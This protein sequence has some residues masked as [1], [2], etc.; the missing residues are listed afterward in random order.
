MTNPPD[1]SARRLRIKQSV[2]HQHLSAVERDL[3]D[4]VN[5]QIGPNFQAKIVLR[6]SA[7]R[8]EVAKRKKNDQFSVPGTSKTVDPEAGKHLREKVLVVSQV[9]TNGA[10]VRETHFKLETASVMGPDLRSGNLYAQ[11]DM[12]AVQN[13]IMTPTMVLNDTSR[14]RLPVIAD[15]HSALTGDQFLSSADVA[16]RTIVGSI[17]HQSNSTMHDRFSEL[18][19]H[20]PTVAPDYRG[21]TQLSGPHLDPNQSKM[22]AGLTAYVSVERGPGMQQSVFD[23]LTSS[24]NLA[25]S[26]YQEGASASTHAGFQAKERRH[27]PNKNTVL[28]IHSAASMQGGLR[29]SVGISKDSEGNPTTLTSMKENTEESAGKSKTERKKSAEKQL[30][31]REAVSQRQGIIP[32]NVNPLVSAQYREKTGAVPAEGFLGVL[33]FGSKVM[34]PGGVDEKGNPL[35]EYAAQM[36]A[37]GSGGMVGSFDAYRMRGESAF[38]D[39]I[40]LMPRSANIRD[41]RIVAGRGAFIPASGGVIATWGQSAITGE[42]IETRMPNMGNRGGVRV[43]NHIL[44][45]G[46]DE[47]SARHI[48]DLIQSPDVTLSYIHGLI[49]D[50]DSTKKG[51]AKFKERIELEQKAIKNLNSTLKSSVEKE[52]AAIDRTSMSPEDIA[53]LEKDKQEDIR[54]SVIKYDRKAVGGKRE[55]TALISSTSYIQ[56]PDSMKGGGFKAMLGHVETD[57]RSQEIIKSVLNGRASHEIS[58]QEINEV[59]LPKFVSEFGLKKGRNQQIS[60]V[61]LQTLVGNSVKNV[62]FGKGW[63]KLQQDKDIEEISQR[64]ISDA[65]KSRLIKQIK[66]GKR[67]PLTPVLVMTHDEIK[68]TKDLHLRTI[69]TYLQQSAPDSPIGSGTAPDSAVTRH[70]KSMGE[71]IRSEYGT[72]GSSTSGMDQEREIEENIR[73]LGTTEKEASESYERRNKAFSSIVTNAMEYGGRPWI[74]TSF[75]HVN[76]EPMGTTNMVNAPFARAITKVSPELRDYLRKNNT[77]SKKISQMLAPESWSEDEAVDITAE[78][79]RTLIPNERAADEHERFEAVKRIYDN[80][81]K[82]RKSTKNAAMRLTI[83]TDEKGN[84]KQIVL[85]SP[86][87][88][89]SLERSDPGTTLTRLVEKVQNKGASTA[90][91]EQLEVIHRKAVQQYAQSDAGQKRMQNFSGEGVNAM[92]LRYVSSPDASPG[93]VLVGNQDI[94]SVAS[95]FGISSKQMIRAMRSGQKF[96]VYV[97]RYPQSEGSGAWYEME[98]RKKYKGAIAVP[99]EANSQFAGDDDGDLANFMAGFRPVTY[100]KNGKMSTEFVPLPGVEQAVIDQGSAKVTALNR[101]ASFYGFKELKSRIQEARGQVEK[102][103]TDQLEHTQEFQD[104][105]TSTYGKIDA[106]KDPEM[107]KRAFETERDRRTIDAMVS[108]FNFV[109][110]TTNRGYHVKKLNLE[111]A[112]K[113]QNT[114]LDAETKMVPVRA[115]ETKGDRASIISN[116]LGQYAVESAP[117]VIAHQSAGEGAAKRDMGIYTIVKNLQYTAETPEHLKAIEKASFDIYGENPIEGLGR[118]IRPHQNPYASASSQALSDLDWIY[119]RALD[120][121]PKH[122]ETKTL[123]KSFF[124][125]DINTSEDLFKRKEMTENMLASFLLAEEV[126]PI[127]IGATFARRGNADQIKFITESA[128]SIKDEI[129]KKRKESGREVTL[130]DLRQIQ[131]FNSIIDGHGFDTTAYAEDANSAV[132][133]TITHQSYINTIARINN[134]KYDDATVDQKEKINDALK[135]YLGKIV[136]NPGT[137][138]KDW[139]TVASMS[140]EKDPTGFWSQAVDQ[141]GGMEHLTNMDPV[142]IADMFGIKLEIPETPGEKDRQMGKRMI[143]LNSFASNPV[144]AFAKLTGFGTDMIHPDIAVDDETQ[145]KYRQAMGNARSINSS[146]KIE[147]GKPRGFNARAS[148]IQSIVSFPDNEKDPRR[149]AYQFADVGS[150]IYKS[151]AVFEIMNQM[152]VDLL[153]GNRTNTAMFRDESLPHGF[154]N[155]SLGKNEYTIFQQTNQQMRGGNKFEENL[156]RQLIDAM[157]NAAEESLK[158]GSTRTK[159][160]QGFL[161]MSGISLSALDE[162]SGMFFSGTPDFFRM[163]GEK[164]KGEDGWQL[165]LQVYDAKSTSVGKALR[166]LGFSIEDIEDV[167]RDKL[168]DVGLSDDFGVY[169]GQISSYVYLAQKMA[170][171]MRNDAAK[172]AGRALE[173]KKKPSSSDPFSDM[174]D[175]AEEE[176]S[177]VE[178][179]GSFKDLDIEGVNV[180]SKYAQHINR[181][182]EML[183]EQKVRMFNGEGNEMTHREIAIGMAE[184]MAAGRIEEGGVI[185]GNTDKSGKRLFTDSKVLGKI[186]SSGLTIKTLLQNNLILS[187]RKLPA[188]GPQS[189]EGMLRAFPRKAKQIAASDAGLRA[190]GFMYHA[191]GLAMMNKNELLGRNRETGQIDEN[192]TYADLSPLFGVLRENLSADPV[193]IR[194]GFSASGNPFGDD[195]PATPSGYRRSWT[196]E[197]EEAD[198]TASVL[199]TMMQHSQLSAQQISS[200]EYIL[201]GFARKADKT[202]SIS[203][204]KDGNAIVGR[205][206]KPVAGKFN[207]LLGDKANELREAVTYKNSAN[208]NVIA[209]DIA[210]REAVIGASAEYGNDGKTTSV[211]SS[212]Q[213]KYMLSGGVR[214]NRLSYIST[215]AR[216]VLNP[217]S[218]KEDAREILKERLAAQAESIQKLHK[219]AELFDAED[220]AKL[221]DMPHSVDDL[222]NAA[223]AELIHNRSTSF[224]QKLMD[225]Y[226][227][228]YEEIGESSIRFDNNSLVGYDPKTGQIG[229]RDEQIENK[230]TAFRL[231]SRMFSIG[232]MM[233]SAQMVMMR[234]GYAS[235]Q[236]MDKEGK[237]LKRVFNQKTN[238]ELDDILNP[239]GESKRNKTKA[240]RAS[241]ARSE[242]IGKKLASLAKSFTKRSKHVYTSKDFAQMPKGGAG[243]NDTN[244]WFQTPVTNQYEGVGAFPAQSDHRSWFVSHHL[245]P[246]HAIAKGLMEMGIRSNQWKKENVDEEILMGMLMTHDLMKAKTT[247]GDLRKKDK[248]AAAGRKYDPEED[249]TPAFDMLLKM[250]M[251]KEK[252]EK[253]KQYLSDMDAVKDPK[254]WEKDQKDQDGNPISIEDKI[255]SLSPEV[256]IASTADAISHRTKGRHGFLNIFSR[257][258]NKAKDKPSTL[259]K[260]AESN[261][262]KSS[263]DSRKILMDIGDVKRSEV[264]SDAREAYD[265]IT[266]E[267]YVSGFAS[268]IAQGL[269]DKFG[270][271]QTKSIFDK[272][273]NAFGDK[274]KFSTID[275][276]TGEMKPFNRTGK[277]RGGRLRKGDIDIVGE[278]EK[279][280]VFSKENGEMIVEPGTKRNKKET[281][282]EFGQEIISPG[283][284]GELYVSPNSA[285]KRRD[286]ES[287]RSQ[288]RI[289]F[290]FGIAKHEGGPVEKETG[291]VVGENKSEL[292]APVFS[293][294]SDEF[295]EGSVRYAYHKELAKALFK[296]DE[297]RTTRGNIVGLGAG[298]SKPEKDLGIRAEYVSLH[299]SIFS[300]RI[301]SWSNWTED[302]DQKADKHLFFDEDEKPATDVL[303]VLKDYF[304]TD[305]PEMPEFHYS[306]EAGK[307][308]ALGFYAS[309][310]NKK[311]RIVLSKRLKGSF[312]VKGLF[313]GLH[314][315]GHFAHFSSLGFDHDHPEWGEDRNSIIKQEAFANKFAKHHGNK[316]IGDTPSLNIFNQRVLL[317][318]SLYEKYVDDYVLSGHDWSKVARANGGPVGKDQSYVAGEHETEEYARLVKEGYGLDEAGPNEGI[319]PIPLGGFRSISENLLGVEAEG[320]EVHTEGPAAG[321][322]KYAEWAAKTARR[323]HG[324]SLGVDVFDMVRS[325][326]GDILKYLPTMRMSDKSR[327]SYMQ[328]VAGEHSSFYR[329]P[330]PHW[331]KLFRAGKNTPK[332]DAEN[333]AGVVIA[334]ISA[335]NSVEHLALLS[336]EIGHYED[337]FAHGFAEGTTGK[338]SWKDPESYEKWMETEA[339]ASINAM[340]NLKQMLDPEK[341]RLASQTLLRNQVLYERTSDLQ[342][343]SM[344]G[345][346]FDDVKNTYVSYREKAKARRSSARAEGGPVESGSSY[347]AGEINTETYASRLKD[348]LKGFLV[349]QEGKKFWNINEGGVSPMDPYGKKFSEIPGIVSDSIREE[350][351]T[352]DPGYSRKLYLQSRGISQG[353]INSYEKRFAF[354][355][356]YIRNPFISLGRKLLAGFSIPFGALGSFGK[357]VKNFL[358]GIRFDKKEDG[359]RSLSFPKFEMD[360][361]SIP[362]WAKKDLS[363]FN[364]GGKFQF[365]K[366]DF[367][368]FF[369]N[370]FDKG[371]AFAGKLM[372]GDGSESPSRDDM[373]KYLKYREEAWQVTKSLDE[374]K[375]SMTPG[376]DELDD[377]DAASVDAE[378]STMAAVYLDKRYKDYRRAKT[379][380]EKLSV[381]Q[382]SFSAVQGSISAKSP[383]DIESYFRVRRHMQSGGMGGIVG[384]VI[385]GA[386]ETGEDIVDFAR[387]IPGAVSK[388][389]AFVGNAASRFA[390][391]AKEI[392]SGI[393][394]FASSQFGKVFN[395]VDA[396]VQTVKQKAGNVFGYAKDV[397]SAL[398]DGYSA[399]LGTGTKPSRGMDLFRNAFDGI[400]GFAER[401]RTGVNNLA[402]RTN[403]GMQRFFYGRTPEKGEV[404][405]YLNNVVEKGNAPYW[406][407]EKYVHEYISDRTGFVG[408]L[409]RTADGAANAITSIG[410][411]PFFNDVRGAISDVASDFRG[412]ASGAASKIND[413]ASEIWS[414]RKPTEKEFVEYAGRKRFGVND[415]DSYVQRYLQNRTGLSNVVNSVGS[416]AGRVALGAGMAAGAVIGGV[417]MGVGAGLGLVGSAIGAVAS[418]IFS[419]AG[420]FA[421]VVGENVQTAATD[422]SSSAKTLFSFA[423]SAL[424][425]RASAAKSFAKQTYQSSKEFAG[426]AYQWAKQSA[427]NVAKFG[428]AAGGFALEGVKAAGTLA[429]IPFLAAGALVAAPFVMA[430][431]AAYRGAQDALFGRKPSKESMDEYLK[432]KDAY[433]NLDKQGFLTSELKDAKNWHEGKRGIVSG[434]SGFAEKASQAVSAFSNR[435]SR[436]ASVFAGKAKGVF[437]NVYSAVSK[438]ASTIWKGEKPHMRSL[439]N[440]RGNPEY[441][442][443]EIKEGRGTADMAYASRYAR[444]RTGLRGMFNTAF[445]GIENATNFVAK[446]GD[447]ASDAIISAGKN[448]LYGKEP[449]QRFIDEYLADKKEYDDLDKEGNL[450]PELKEAKSWLAGKRG[451]LGE[452]KKAKERIGAGIATA[453]TFPSRARNAIT[454][455][456]KKFSMRA[457]SSAK[458]GAFS[459]RGSVERAAQKLLWGDSSVNKWKPGMSDAEIASEMEKDNVFGGVVQGGF[460]GILGTLNSISESGVVSKAIDSFKSIGKSIYEQSGVKGIYDYTVG[461]I[462]NF[463]H[464][465][466]DEESDGGF[467]GKIKKTIANSPISDREW[468]EH[469]LGIDLIKKALG[470]AKKVIGGVLQGAEKAISGLYSKV[471]DTFKKIASGVKGAI[472]GFARGIKDTA[473][474]VVGKKA[475]TKFGKGIAAFRR[476]MGLKNEGDYRI[477]EKRG[478]TRSAAV[479][480]VLKE[481]GVDVKDASTD[482]LKW[483][484]TVLGKGGD[485]DTPFPGSSTKP[486]E[487]TDAES[488]KESGEKA[489]SALAMLD[490]ERPETSVEGPDSSATDST[491]AGDPGKTA[492][493]ADEEE[494][495]SDAQIQE[496]LKTMFPDG[497]M[498]TVYSGNLEGEGSR[499]TDVATMFRGMMF[500]QYKMSQKLGGGIGGILGGMFGGS[501]KGASGKWK[502]SPAAM[503]RLF[504]KKVKDDK[505][506]ES[507]V[508]RNDFEDD[509]GNLKLPG[510]SNEDISKMLGSHEIGSKEAEGISN[511]QAVNAR[512]HRA[513]LENFD[514]G[515]KFLETELSKAAPG[516]AENE[517]IANMLKTVRN[518]RNAKMIMGGRTSATTISGLTHDQVIEKAGA[519]NASVQDNDKY[520]ADFKKNMKSFTDELVK[521]SNVMKGLNENI[522]KLTATTAKAYETVK[523]VAETRDRMR[524]HAD[525]LEKAG[526]GSTEEGRQSI[527]LARE[528]QYEAQSQL[529]KGS[530]LYESIRS[531]HGDKVAD[532]YFAEFGASK[533]KRTLAQKFKDPMTAMFASHFIR[534]MGMAIREGVMPT[535]NKATEYGMTVDREREYLARVGDSSGRIN[536]PGSQ[537]LDVRQNWNRGMARDSANAMGGLGQNNSLSFLRGAN[538]ALEPGI[539]L[540]MG[541]A[542]LNAAGITTLG[543]P[544]VLGLALAATVATTAAYTYGASRNPKEMA[545]ASLISESGGSPFDRSMFTGFANL[546]SGDVKKNNI[547]LEEAKARVNL[548]QETLDNLS[549]AIERERQRNPESTITDIE[550]E[551]GGDYRQEIPTA[552]TFE[553][554]NILKPTDHFVRDGVVYRDQTTY[555]EGNRSEFLE[556]EKQNQKSS[557]EKLEKL[558]KVEEFNNFEARLEKRSA[559]QTDADRASISGYM[560]KMASFDS[561]DNLDDLPFQK[562]LSSGAL[563]LFRETQS[564]EGLISPYVEYFK[565]KGVN[566]Q[567]ERNKILAISQIFAGDPGSKRYTAFFTA[568]TDRSAAGENNDVTLQM[569]HEYGKS[570]GA[571]GF[572][573]GSKYFADRS[574][575]GTLLTQAQIE[576]AT[577]NARS[578]NAEQYIAAVTM[579]T[580][581]GFNKV[582]SGFEDSIFRDAHSTPVGAFYGQLEYAK[583]MQKFDLER[584]NSEGQSIRPLDIDKIMSANMEQVADVSEWMRSGRYDIAAMSRISER[585]KDKGAYVKAASLSQMFQE[586]ASGFGRLSKVLSS[587]FMEAAMSEPTGQVAKMLSGVA[588]G[589][590]F[591]TSALYQT[592]NHMNPETKRALVSSGLSPMF[593][594][595]TGDQI[596][597]SSM[598]GLVYNTFRSETSG[599]LGYGQQATFSMVPDLAA[600][601]HPDQSAMSETQYLRL[602]GQNVDKITKYW[603][604]Q[605]EM[606]PMASRRNMS[607]A[608]KK[609][610][611]STLA[612]T[613]KKVMVNGK[614][615][616]IA[617]PSA[618]QM[619]ANAAAIQSQLA[620]AGA[621]YANLVLQH[622]Y[623]L[624][625][626]R[627]DA[628]YQLAQQYASF[629]G[630]KVTSPFSKTKRTSRKSG[631]LDQDMSGGVEAQLDFGRGQMEYQ[632]LERDIQK[633]DMVANF[634][635]NMTRMGWQAQ[636]SY[637]ERARTLT[638]AGWQREDFNLQRSQISMGRDMQSYSFGF[639]ARE[640]AIGKQ[641]YNEDFAYN[642]KMRQMQFGWQMEDADIN[643]R[644]ATGFE[645]KQLIKSKE[646]EVISFNEESNQNEKVNK[647]QQE[648]FKREEEKFK[649]EIDHYKKSIQLED[650]QFNKSVERFEQEQ[651]WQEEDFSIQAGRLMQEQAW[652]EES[653]ERQMERFNLETEQ[654]ELQKNNQQVL[655][656]DAAI[657]QEAAFALADK[658]YQHSL[659]AA[660]AAA[661][662]AKLA[663]EAQDH[664]ERAGVTVEQMTLAMQKWAEG[665]KWEEVSKAM[666]NIIR[667][668]K[669]VNNIPDDPTPGSPRP[670]VQE[671]ANGGY[672]NHNQS[673]LVGERGPEII[674]TD[675]KGRPFVIPNS[676]IPRGR[677]SSS[678]SGEV[679]HVH[680]MMD[681]DEIATYTA[682]KANT[683][684][685]RN[686]RRAFNG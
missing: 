532:D 476:R 482:Q 477:D 481:K 628:R 43:T 584:L 80:A 186:N 57:P 82:R 375:A 585:P 441:F 131:K 85:A 559:E 622:E 612:G 121:L 93:K 348:A 361:I 128:Q 66:K 355:K 682:G 2:N 70:I 283:E 631:D 126:T 390:N 516:S 417:G 506:A 45:F 655:A 61:A 11:H 429:T 91:I 596:F 68:Y 668:Y 74:L 671:N 146:G 486:A 633:R 492:A 372:F 346:T 639:Q 231:N 400:L 337:D 389:A 450:A 202:G 104:H 237:E 472:S 490:D 648:A 90:T 302:V 455:I 209:D 451:I 92:A 536:D 37:V 368:K 194:S 675:N 571:R 479:A 414:G 589:D 602:A 158:P 113:E 71:M 118:S 508:A 23:A 251:S 387:A 267:T 259:Q 686:R 160:T 454:D 364:K 172:A 67:A 597:K 174:E 235:L 357:G 319:R 590:A 41:L 452:F 521:G 542:G 419:A 544:A 440:Y 112:G 607:A 167:T 603:D 108:G 62:L 314:E 326:Y 611:S 598:N 106:A 253:V 437:D 165:N 243:I 210:L 83:G 503:R 69:L 204:Q 358:G 94:D 256:R 676:A 3:V 331:G 393:A 130:S 306:D 552:M 418:P 470:G 449:E 78:D 271:E 459:I 434:V 594:M 195:E 343:S 415:Q 627:P 642:K 216:N 239:S 681:S 40:T 547:S 425:E 144:E 34:A 226:H 467:I 534:D 333:Y 254:W 89:S 276:A 651:K 378:P 28:I 221:T 657:K 645:R 683:L 12:V 442:D 478:E 593:D 558:K 280:S 678:G 286:S 225:R 236:T 461:A 448:F 244:F 166:N 447:T 520:T 338:P 680:V 530:D 29:G 308:G 411:S 137:F 679:I 581:A 175:D 122:E 296:D 643:I 468:R 292:Y 310:R 623:E 313:V 366:L 145:S 152:A 151:S 284:D 257:L 430:G 420:K 291:A 384:G 18:T 550:S 54:A 281:V 457:S 669:M 87:A 136:S 4:R 193:A 438:T 428:V 58:E 141:A 444:E 591:S 47:L 608:D 155:L 246:M 16:V 670:R 261:K 614:A 662:A 171:K 163:I 641:Q 282:G 264:M 412:M 265:P 618:L 462:Q 424:E 356:A 407:E 125:S 153:A 295:D 487:K 609:R 255:K 26:G 272:I 42:T 311:G 211:D 410:K 124:V 143:D 213:D 241:R 63:Q 232:G 184:A 652:A 97:Q 168:N 397:Y 129:D 266:D 329:S 154:A 140:R 260:I 10:T 347:V 504:T 365:P 666:D 421:S 568:A 659:A 304:S 630:G 626:E 524:Q 562:S 159:P 526:Y 537:F 560:G 632:R 496:M 523:S 363:W 245:K 510:W 183:S 48:H 395:A 20:Y 14:S 650:E 413:F 157:N 663:A 515:V 601:V 371:K 162:P 475:F 635:Q 287:Y 316:M 431:M 500:G 621:T 219:Q 555:F 398:S 566:N 22:A 351:E 21:I 604:Q 73:F 582:V 312:G 373:R 445:E 502:F 548:S 485:P 32:Q 580:G 49:K 443:A 619:D 180:K 214:T 220:Y 150:Q 279:E 288:Q 9:D 7:T 258:T 102:Y 263:K 474:A 229:V 88:F 541:L 72:T 575:T 497:S 218:N 359:S 262:N 268:D 46:N 52:Y 278:V 273:K 156:Q 325:H 379:D 336:H 426:T 556:K 483:A 423:Q 203:V 65:Q 408:F 396:R 228:Q 665:T 6:P 248:E 463:L 123:A 119:Q 617:G 377:K 330:L 27:V 77:A 117:Q 305:F 640:M 540:G 208:E 318:Q 289:R 299:K 512:G 182:S 103:M 545:S 275:P 439:I 309:Q 344:R 610:V 317:G 24:D 342:E 360:D 586:N 133:A 480:R 376:T 285:V 176:G 105:M 567:E 352:G 188:S 115:G 13:V 435:A 138:R 249:K 39:E 427:A 339:R 307:I 625:Y 79:F 499:Q 60:D 217:Y 647:R 569:T 187:S 96:H 422:F 297:A 206:A 533:S 684:A 525:T 25:N 660:G 572:Y 56:T 301:V 233:E 135:S 493:T 592:F 321:R 349:G 587:S 107:Y 215:H 341:Y 238:E 473:G 519:L 514:Q 574:K 674:T 64:N 484:H 290:G 120:M 469:Y 31:K 323:A 116:A 190:L 402:E 409:N 517:G 212:I 197:D 583:N 274:S 327:D 595:S 386:R 561:S 109:S 543:G 588:S 570:V 658:T 578:M 549:K 33:M 147:E 353:D 392:G 577:E 148:S 624:A 613:T 332:D 388:G 511:L 205:S 38:A 599:S 522:D 196:T 201:R 134:G 509:S 491:P 432:N 564:G 200:M 656:D 36:D 169:S 646:R 563:D 471:P 51:H 227:P 340:K 142:S 554:F 55:D 466:P 535:V 132:A 576:D 269:I 538:Q 685:S 637:R 59:I 381:L 367:G 391:K 573:A 1:Q 458:S 114:Q 605:N 240:A 380:K 15:K 489:D 19:Q 374:T 369:G 401:A 505:G 501:R 667:M 394:G 527:A 185:V 546:F 192:G 600:I 53:Q 224:H 101:F 495:K 335:N 252:A 199:S 81:V 629:F 672:F 234:M 436:T 406:D 362:D 139:E 498:G 404:Q 95:G 345:E 529:N 110:E 334:P 35:P 247:R 178:F 382:S 177:D 649:K 636:D 328:E 465:E 507:T 664:M 75:P 324:T 433:D 488:E 551:G 222:S 416:F 84:P 654:F 453:K 270:D 615:K 446:M 223:I 620:S 673:V 127:A 320:V 86:H 460:G 616:Y 653:F 17:K 557:I 300:N 606:S 98:Y 579:Q 494:A 44:S 294:V 677:S 513:T 383:Q 198:E 322:A 277:M 170:K 191:T 100:R 565:S 293:S 99:T 250:G 638:R 528:K 385:R 181:L 350:E 8:V 370:L 399:R 644:R 111:F 464:G 207:Y 50:P 149:A 189:V 456:A 303:S 531:K 634:A 230:V 553:E 179:T 161:H 354:R 30:W 661:H 76:S 5:R 164:P 403:A 405:K 315:L 173:K 539:S 242:G 518:M 298:K